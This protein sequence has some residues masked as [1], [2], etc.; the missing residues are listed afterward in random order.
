MKLKLLEAMCHSMQLI[1]HEFTYLP[2]RNMDNKNCTWEAM[3]IH[4]PYA[5][6]GFQMLD[7]TLQLRL[8]SPHRAML[9]ERTNRA[10]RASSPAFPA[11]PQHA[12]SCLQHSCTDG[13]MDSPHAICLTSLVSKHRQISPNKLKFCFLLRMPQLARS[14]S[15]CELVLIN[16]LQHLK[17]LQLEGFDHE[18]N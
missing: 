16:P 3:N 18:L 15:T 14:K 10:A 9:G 11:T 4:E 8:R 6:I 17:E 12:Q 7:K 5:F 13:H 1:L 2:W